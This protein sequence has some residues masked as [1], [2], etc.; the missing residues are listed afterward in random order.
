VELMMK[1]GL[2]GRVKKGSEN[3]K[4]GGKFQEFEDLFDNL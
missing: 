2:K 3:L 1:D 4:I